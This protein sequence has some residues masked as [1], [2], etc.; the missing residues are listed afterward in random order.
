MSAVNLQQIKDDFLSRYNKINKK[1]IVC[2]GTGCVSSGSLK[3]YDTFKEKIKALGYNVEVILDKEE[4]ADKTIVVKRSGC[5]GFCQQGPLV[6]ILPDN[7]L[8]CKVKLEDVDEIIEKTVLKNEPIERLLY[9]NPRDG[10]RYHNKEDIPYYSK[11]KFITLALCGSIDSGS[12][13]EYIANDGYFGAEK[14]Y[15]TMTDKEICDEVLASGLRGRGGAGFPTGRKWDFARIEPEGKKYIICNGDEGDPG[16]FMDCS[17]MEGNPHSVIEGMMIAA[18]AFGADEGY[19]YVRTEYPRAV[20]RMGKAIKDAEALGILGDNVFGTGYNF[21]LQIMEGAGAFVCGEETALI[22]S[23]EGER[24]MPIPKPP[25]PAHEGLFKKPTCINNVETLSIVPNIIRNGAAEYKKI[26]TETS[27]GTKTFSITGNIVNTGL[28]EVPMGATLRDLIF[29]IGGG[30]TDN[31]GNPT[32]D[33]FKSVQ[34]GG[35]SGGCLTPEHLDIPID[36][37]S[38]K[39]VGAIVGSGGLVVMNKNTCMIQIAKFFMTFTQSESCGKCTMCREGTKQMLQMLTD[40]TEGKGTPEMLEL[41]EKTAKAV[42]KGSLCALGKTAPN[43]V[44]STLRFFRDEYEAH[45][46]D[47]KCPTKQCKALCA[48]VIDKDKCKGCGLCA[49]Q[50]PVGAISGNVKDKYV[51]DDEK[52]IKCG[53][54]VSTCKFGAIEG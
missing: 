10:K 52:C 32:D 45:I 5:Q 46:I 30:V 43:P 37:D 24:G 2:G 25:F 13:E 53:A 12:I 23:V 40:I 51:I 38:L 49:K 35:P 50:C 28:V 6:T 33:M 17:V 41:L 4:S 36:Y 16:A 31:A 21:K 34:I 47:K 29:E 22:H 9:L 3:I 44:L 8:Y 26:G 15:K 11:Q 18:K 19:V 48:P 39:A 20:E 27:A 14:A 54:C 42:S 7:L 1:I